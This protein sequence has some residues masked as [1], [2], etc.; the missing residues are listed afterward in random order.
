MPLVATHPESTLRL[1]K[2]LSATTGLSARD[3]A[4]RNALKVAGAVVHEPQNALAVRRED[5]R[6]QPDERVNLLTGAPARRRFAAPA[7]PPMQTPRLAP[8]PPA[9]PPPGQEQAAALA[10]FLA[11]DK[12]SPSQRAAQFARLEETRNGIAALLQQPNLTHA[13]VAQALDGA[14]KA[15]VLPVAEA[16]A[17]MLALPND[18]AMLRAELIHRLKFTVAAMVHFAA[19]A[20]AN[21]ANMAR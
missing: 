17:L 20:P 15:G 16:K 10:K 14:V 7:A 13:H 3:V 12:F 4:E 5:T 2:P 11:V 19:A 18:P 21:P 8:P 9:P 1:S 6:G